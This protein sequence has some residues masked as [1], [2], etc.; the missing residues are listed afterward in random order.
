M[1]L[2]Q[3]S[4]VTAT[5]SNPARDVSDVGV[6]LE[7]S[8]PGRYTSVGATLPFSGTWLLSVSARYGEF[9]LVDFGASFDV[10]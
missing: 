8:G 3:P 10:G 2:D 1:P 5:L 7:P 6:Q 9:D 4:E